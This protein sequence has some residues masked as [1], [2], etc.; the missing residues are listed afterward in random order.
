MTTNP[1]D[2]LWLHDRVERMRAG[3]RSAGDDLLRAVSE[4]TEALARRMLRG[5]PGV[6]ARAETG[7]IV[8]G[9]LVRMLAALRDLKP[10]S[11]RDFVNLAAVQLLRE[12]SDL[13]RHFAAR[14]GRRLPDPATADLGP[15]PREPTDD[16]ELWSR[17]HAAVEDLPT[18]EREVMSLIFY[19][20]Q[21][22]AQAALVLN[23]SERT[24]YRWWA[25]ACLRLNERLGG[26]LPGDLAT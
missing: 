25:A 17:F 1:F 13:A 15:A 24:V 3:D 23:V 18:E 9:A 6:R 7:D 16:L 2:T 14:A 5:Y 19:H 26:A 12:L 21:T 11:T 4:R 8:Q 20:G 10:A 22:R